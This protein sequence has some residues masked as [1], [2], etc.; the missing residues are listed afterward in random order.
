MNQDNNSAFRLLAV[1]QAA[2]RYPENKPTQEVWSETFCIQSADTAGI[3]RSL[4]AL[5]ES[6]DEI[7]KLIRLIPG[8]NYDLYLECLPPIRKGVSYPHIGNA[9]QSVRIYFA[10]ENLRGLQ[11]CADLLAKHYPEASIP[12]ADLDQISKLV[13]EQFSEVSNSTIDPK[14]RVILLDLLEAIRRCV[15]EYQIRGAKGIRQAITAALDT[16]TQNIRKKPATDYTKEDKVFVARFLTILSKVD[17]A[18]SKAMTYLPLL[19]KLPEWA[20]SVK[21]YLSGNGGQP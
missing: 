6:I 14:L 5:I 19:Q 9:W 12:K 1:L 3:F 17:T 16:L 13:D 10:P 18:A 20:E 15:A 8:T 4:V 7:E 21:A 2:L 11:F